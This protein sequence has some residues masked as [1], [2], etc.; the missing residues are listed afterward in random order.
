MFK[1]PHVK[2]TSLG[3]VN[4]MIHTTKVVINFII[5]TLI[6]MCK[7]HGDLKMSNLLMLGVLIF[8]IGSD[9]CEI[10]QVFVAYG[11]F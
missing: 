8:S 9:S 5:K 3:W 2:Y 1:F 10:A 6:A 11:G 4:E 7:S